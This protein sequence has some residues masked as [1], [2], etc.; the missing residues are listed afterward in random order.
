MLDSPLVRR[1]VSLALEEDEAHADL[2]AALTVPESHRSTAKLIARQ[3]L[4][5]SGL[6][7]AAVIARE[8]GFQLAVTAAVGEGEEVDD[9]A[10]LVE[11]EG[12]TR[13][14]LAVERTMLNF[15][16]RMCGV[17]TYT[18]K[19]VS[20][21]AGLTILDTRKTMPGWRLLD[22]Y[23]TRVGGAS[24][25]RMSLADMI[26]VKNNHIDAHPGGIRAALQ[27]VH[28]SKPAGIRWEVEVRTLEELS[29][30]LEFNPDI[31]MLD[32]FTDSDVKFAMQAISGATVRPMVEVSGGVRADRL[33]VLRNLGVDAVSAGSLTTQAPNVDI[34][35][36]IRGALRES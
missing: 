15:L 8:A 3:P 12:P 24:N 5:A 20:A 10:A 33:A 16:Q 31:V 9:G 21:A 11:L 4:V 23:S 22:K 26:L 14:I 35:L 36:R 18:R 17:A 19:F 6:P 32:N 27:S 25:H 30:A 13:Q 1:L 34:S 7:I 28:D 2:T 29:V